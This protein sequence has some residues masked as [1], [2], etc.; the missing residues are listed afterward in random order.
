MILVT[1]VLFI[2]FIRTIQNN[3][4]EYRDSIQNR[5]IQTLKESKLADEKA[6]AYTRLFINE[7]YI[8]NEG[9][10]VEIHNPTAFSVDLSDFSIENSSGN[11]VYKFSPN[12]TIGPDGYYIVDNSEDEMFDLINDG[13]EYVSLYYS[14]EYVIDHINVPI[15]ASDV[16]FGR[17]DMVDMSIAFLNPTRGDM[18]DTLIYTSNDK[19]YFS[20]PSGVYEEEIVVEIHADPDEDIY[21]TLDGSD[22]TVESIKYEEPIVIGNRSGESNKFSAIKEVSIY[23]VSTPPDKVDKATILKAISIDKKGNIR[24]SNTSTFFVGNQYK[25]GY[26]ELPIISIVSDPNNLFDYWDGI[27]VRG[28]LYD[29]S[30]MLELDIEEP[31]YTD[32]GIV[33]HEPYANY[34]DSKN[35]IADIQLFENDGR[36]TYEDEVT[37]SVYDDGYA[38][39]AQKS[40]KI[41]DVILNRRINSSIM[42]L[43]PSNEKGST[44]L[45]SN[46]RSDQYSLARDQLINQSMQNTSV[47]TLVYNPVMIF[48][49]GEFWGIYNATEMYTE[50]FI[51]YQFDVEDSITIIKNQVTINREKKMVETYTS[52]YFGSDEVVSEFQNILEFVSSNDMSLIHNYE[53]ISQAVDIESMIDYYACMLYVGNTEYLKNEH[54]IWRTNSKNDGYEDGKWRWLIY[55][56]DFSLSQDE[57]SNYE[58]NSFLIPELRYDKLFSNLIV[59]NDF[60]VRY[61]NR[62]FDLGN[63]EFSPIRINEL[64]N[65]LYETQ[66]KAIKKQYQRYPIINGEYLMDNSYKDIS[67]FFLNRLEYISNH[68][69]EYLLL[70]GN[71]I[72]V[73]ISIGDYDNG[74][75]MVNNRAVEVNQEGK[76][77]GLYLSTVPIEIEFVPNDGKMFNG[78]IDKNGNTISDGWKSDVVINVSEE[79]AEFEARMK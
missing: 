39:N 14:E 61:V 53:F 23:Y 5:S 59:N 36:R 33:I 78:W 52:K 1:V 70:E 29:D 11:H 50:E 48:I 4:D 30:I 69:N 34:L 71:L 40:L 76:W 17:V 27:Y 45:L 41:E 24:K 12:Q 58:I 18:N 51:K 47:G 32:E 3:Q 26:G 21:Y 55:E 77:S 79:N 72:E 6:I 7:V 56:S 68:V 62:I 66:N 74:R 15:L 28:K 75:L 38:D 9:F 54:Y 31:K 10:W 49:N 37:L 60:M 63:E 65:E 16:S 13:N 20:L 73:N 42:Q 57:Y 8:D 19:P 22:P 35:I 2:V 64:L 44:L 25:V 43:I 67:E 46:G